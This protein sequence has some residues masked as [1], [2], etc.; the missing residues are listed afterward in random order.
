MF[1][2][3]SSSDLILPHF[4]LSE[5][6]YH[7]S[8]CSSQQLKSGLE[9][10]LPPHPHSVHLSVSMSNEPWIYPL[11]TD[12]TLVH[13]TVVSCLDHCSCLL[14]TFAASPCKP[15]VANS[16]GD[17]LEHKTRKMAIPLLKPS[18]GPQLKT[19]IQG[20]CN[21]EGG[22]GLVAGRPHFS[23]NLPRLWDSLCGR[24]LP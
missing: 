14:T 12:T 21:L 22:Q 20:Y 19:Q 16:Q 6:H 4:F 7:L 8:N 15:R 18:N 24:L 13:T 17:L 3:V 9:T 11:L 10:S 5:R 23:T 1:S 2:W